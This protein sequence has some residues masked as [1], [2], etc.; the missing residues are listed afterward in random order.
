MVGGL[1]V[2]D[3]MEKVPVDKKEKPAVGIM[4]KEWMFLSNCRQCNTVDK[5]WFVHVWCCQP[6]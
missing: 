3:R 4:Y 6:M 5:V 1:D 2:I